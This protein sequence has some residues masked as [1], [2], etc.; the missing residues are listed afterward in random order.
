MLIKYKI[1]ILIFQESFDENIYTAAGNDSKK[2]DIDEVLG[3]TEE[4]SLKAESILPERRLPKETSLSIMSVN[5][6]TTLHNAPSNRDEDSPAMKYLAS[7]LHTLREVKSYK[8]GEKEWESSFEI[9]DLFSSTLDDMTWIGAAKKFTPNFFHLNPPHSEGTIDKIKFAL[10]F[11]NDG[12]INLAVCG[13]ILHLFF[14]DHDG[15]YGFTKPID[16]L[17]APQNEVYARLNVLPKN[18]SWDGK[19]GTPNIVQIL[20]CIHLN[21]ANPAVDT[22]AGCHLK[23]AQ[24]PTFP[25]AMSKSGLLQIG[26][27]KTNHDG[28]C[29]DVR[30]SN[31]VVAVVSDYDSTKMFL[32]DLILNMDDMDIVDPAAPHGDPCGKLFRCIPDYNRMNPQC[33][34]Y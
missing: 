7:Q 33:I 18:C 12:N 26:D 30:E 14:H 19:T 5:A 6:D 9:A 15:Y 16:V 31:V 13:Q 10:S 21:A 4:F 28:L 2:S 11:R 3:L 20:R 25:I 17:V 34:Y 24:R 29:Y 32:L 8:S 1:H 22:P 23:D 27:E